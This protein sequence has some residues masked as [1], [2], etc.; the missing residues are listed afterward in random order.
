MWKKIVCLLAISSVAQ[1]NSLDQLIDSSSSIVSQIDTSIKLVGAAT[2]YAHQGSGLS[3][4]TLSSTGHISAEQVD[5]YNSALSNFSNNYQPYGAPVKQV[6]ENMAMDSLAEMETHIDTFVEVTVELVSVQQVAEKAAEAST[7]KQ[8]EEV[9]T[10]VQ[11][12]QEM[13]TIDQEDVQL[14][15]DTVDNIETSANEAA[16]YLAVAQSEAADFLQ[17]SIEDKNTTSADVN[18]FYDS[19]QQWVAMGYNTTRN[20]TAVYL[21][22]NDAFGLDLYYS[23]ADILAVG[24]ESEFYRT[25]P[26]ALGYDC[27][28]NMDCEQ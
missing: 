26:I 10:F 17:Q 6:L 8:E 25:S 22:G 4:G 2:E 19:N 27:F 7:P 15:N 28:I 24:A 1:S 16:A 14:F 12:N 11:Q 13:L 21:N 20:L 3:D 18:I 23:E 9:Q 5:A